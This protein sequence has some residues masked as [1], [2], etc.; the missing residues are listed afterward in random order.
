VGLLVYKQ[1]LDIAALIGLGFMIVGI[2]IIN[3]FSNSTEL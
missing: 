1:Q 2:I 3:V